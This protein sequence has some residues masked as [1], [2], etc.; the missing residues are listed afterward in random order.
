MIRLGIRSAVRRHLALARHR[1]IY[2]EIKEF[3]MIHE[4]IFCDNLRLAEKAREVPGCVVECGVW[5][6]GMSAGL[7]RI[8]G[9]DRH[10]YLFDSFEGLPPAKRIDGLRALEYQRN[11]T[12]PYYHDNCTAPPDFARSAMK[13]VGAN[14]VTLVP[15]LFNHTLPAF[16]LHEP[17]ALLRLDGDWYDST[18]ECL[19]HLFDRVARNGMII[20]D[21]YYTWDGCAR[22]VHDFLSERKATERIQSLNGSVCYLL[23][24]SDAS[25]LLTENY[26]DH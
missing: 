12:S 9:Q 8:L 15:G 26:H 6:G 17:I 5:R 1:R 22:A 23:K 7:C 13:L 3:T 16:E 4:S 18:I 20:I 19:R 25:Q 2:A 14:Q 21:D 11:K 24:K 10:Y